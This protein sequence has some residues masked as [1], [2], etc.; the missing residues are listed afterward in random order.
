MSRPTDL[1]SAGITRRIVP[2]TIVANGAQTPSAVDAEGGQRGHLCVDF[3][4]GTDNVTAFKLYDSPD[5]ATWTERTDVTGTGGTTF[6]T[7]GLTCLHVPRL[8]QYN[9]VTYTGGG[10]NADSVISALLIATELR[11]APAASPYS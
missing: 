3:K 4:K 6:D 8:R 9:K 7:T 2:A 1:I 10:A 5:N 11:V